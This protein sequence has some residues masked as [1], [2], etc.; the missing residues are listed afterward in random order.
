MIVYTMLCVVYLFFYNK[1]HNVF[2]LDLLLYR[3]L[4]GAGAPESVHIFYIAVHYV[5]GV[6]HK[7]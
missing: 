1:A 4:L 2:L 7:H 6:Q 5:C 3:Y